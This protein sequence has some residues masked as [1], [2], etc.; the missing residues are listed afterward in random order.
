MDGRKNDMGSR[1]GSL[2]SPKY[3]VVR[4]DKSFSPGER[5]EPIIVAT[6]LVSKSLYQGRLAALAERGSY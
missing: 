1:I 2:R 3:L 6:I 4:P 5:S